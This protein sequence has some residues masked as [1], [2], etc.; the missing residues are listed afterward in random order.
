MRLSAPDGDV[1]GDV[2]GE[3]AL[4]GFACIRIGVCN[5]VTVSTVPNVTRGAQ[6]VLTHR[7]GVCQYKARDE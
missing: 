1:P 5:G 7:A 2:P 6:G 4:P 3:V